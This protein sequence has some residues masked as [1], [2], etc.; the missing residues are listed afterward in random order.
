VIVVVNDHVMD[1][2][3]DDPVVD[4]VAVVVAAGGHERQGHAERAEQEGGTQSC[5]HGRS[6]VSGCIRARFDPVWARSVPHESDH[7]GG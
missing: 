3:V 6:S 1:D 7:Y 2:V 4:H 5:H